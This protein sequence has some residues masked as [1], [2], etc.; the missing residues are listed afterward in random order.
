[1]SKNSN[2]QGRAY[3]YAWIRT[4]YDALCAKR[5]TIIVENTSLEADRRAWNAV[6]RDKQK[7]FLISSKAAIDTLLELEPRLIENDEDVLSLELQKDQNGGKGDVRDIVVKRN[8]LNWEIGLSIKHNHDAVKHCRLAASLDF[9]EQW[10][11]VPCSSDYWNSVTPIFNKL[12][13]AKNQKKKW[14]EITNKAE[15]V[16]LPLLNSFMEE[17]KRTVSKDSSVP[18][19]MVEYLLGV[20]DYY[21]IVG[22]D[23]RKLTSIKT[24]NVHN[25]LNKPSKVKISTISVPIVKLPTELAAFKFKTNSKTTLEAYLNNG[26]QINFRIHNASTFVEPSLKFDVQLIG[27]PITVI[28]IVC[29]WKSLE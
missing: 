23:S 19:K 26:W 22:V 25:T 6:S 28:E 7:L 15:N 2:D 10:F 11:N 24:F 9:G 4:I 3:E 8:E 27:L 17:V 16:Y 29:H 5:K 1:M 13:E 12:K 21:K 14:R 20:K 18:R